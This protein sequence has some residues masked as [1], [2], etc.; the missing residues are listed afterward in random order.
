M[1]TPTKPVDLPAWADSA[2]KSLRVPEWLARPTDMALKNGIRL[3]VQTERTSPTVTLIGSIK[4]QNQ[5]QTPAGKDGVADILEGLFSYGTK[6][7]G[8]VAFQKALDD[9]G[10]SESAGAGFSLKVLTQ[11]FARGVQLLADN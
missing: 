5:L 11:D 7:L 9:I 2:V 8:R 1:S 4:T 3:I 10:A 6:T